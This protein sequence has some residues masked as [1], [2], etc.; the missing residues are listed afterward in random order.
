[1]EPR[2]LT[3]DAGESLVPAI[4]ELALDAITGKAIIQKQNCVNQRTRGYQGCGFA[5]W[6]CLHMGLIVSATGRLTLGIPALRPMQ[7]GK[8]ATAV[9]RF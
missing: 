3:G 1:M 6:R 5:P 2:R 7:I 8:W 9:A 4:F